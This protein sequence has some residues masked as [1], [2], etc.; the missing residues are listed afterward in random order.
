M[1]HLKSIDLRFI[2]RGEVKGPTNIALLAIDDHSVSIEGRWPW[3]RNKMAKLIENARAYGAKVLSFD[4]TFSE[5]SQQPAL[6]VYNDLSR[7]N[8]KNKKKINPHFIF[9][10]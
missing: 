5:P 7:I 4:I 3:P 10:L 6:D 9:F 1:A 2:N 8:G